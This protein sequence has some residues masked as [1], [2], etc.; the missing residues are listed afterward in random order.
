MLIKVRPAINTQQLS[1]GVVNAC[2]GVCL[3]HTRSRNSAFSEKSDFA[4][5]TDARFPSV[6]VRCVDASPKVDYLGT[7][8]ADYFI[9][10]WVVIP[11]LRA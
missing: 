6:S 2:T 5:I 7:S 1:S 9:L 3:T 11:S 8:I 4:K 10:R